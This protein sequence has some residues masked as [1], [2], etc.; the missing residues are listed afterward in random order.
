MSYLEFVATVVGFVFVWLEAKALIWSWP[1]AIVNAILLFFLFYQV[2][3]YPDMFLQIFYFVACLIGWWR[4]AHPKPGEEDRKN[5]LKVSYM[6]HRQI[7]ILISCSV[8][9]TLL[10]GTF[11]KNLHE[12]YPTIFQKPSAFPYLDSFVTVVS[13]ATTFFMIQKKIESWMAW[14]IVDALATYL[15]FAKGIKFVGIQ[16]LI[17]SFISG[18][19]LWNWIKEF[20]SYG[21]EGTRYDLQGTK[22]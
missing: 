17:F 8:I 12:L 1:M 13:I 6:S 18:Y 2:Q 10:L 4:W 5:E 20:K 7:I 15:Y 19:G 14:I 9:G 11:A 21:K 16:Y 22:D 3:L